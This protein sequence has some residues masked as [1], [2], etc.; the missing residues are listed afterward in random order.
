M[1][2]K[3]NGDIVFVTDEELQGHNISLQFPPWLCHVMA[4]QH[5]RSKY[6]VA[7]DKSNQ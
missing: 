2:V 3:P 7:A 4:L 1:G 5:F 6:I